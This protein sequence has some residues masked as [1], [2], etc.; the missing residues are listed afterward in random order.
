MLRTGGGKGGLTEIGRYVAMVFESHAETFDLIIAPLDERFTVDVSR[1]V[2]GMRAHVTVPQS[3][4]QEAAVRGYFE[5][6]RL[7]VPENSTVPDGFFPN[8]PV[9]LTYD[10]VPAPHDAAHL[11]LL[12]ATMLSEVCE[13]T[14]DSGLIFRYHEWI[15]LGL[16]GSPPPA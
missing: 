9:Y 14:E 1:M 16:P 4:E 7:P 3:T 13:L 2:G 6:H 12:V 8:L 5:R 10:L 11:T 15:P